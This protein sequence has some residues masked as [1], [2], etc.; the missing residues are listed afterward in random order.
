MKVLHVI[1]SISPRRGG[2]SKAVI[3]MVKALRSE[4]IDA[5]IV[6]TTDSGEYRDESLVPGEWIDYKNVPVWIH[7]CINSTSRILREYLFSP[8]MTKWLMQ[9]IKEFELVHIHAIFSYPSTIA[10]IIAR[11]KGVPYIVRTI[12]QLD[13]WSLQQ[14]PRRKKTMLLLAE[15][16]NLNC[17]SAI[18]VTSL[19]E[20]NQVCKLGLNV[21]I[22]N[23]RLGI[24]NE[25]YT[26]QKHSDS[27]VASSYKK[28]RF[29]FLSRIHPKKQ[30]DMV[31]RAFELIEK[32]TK[33]DAWELFIV[34]TGETNYIKELKKLSGELSISDKVHW[35]GYLEGK[36]KFDLLKSMDWFV[37]PSLSENFGIS[38]IEALSVGVPVIISK[39]VGVSTVVNSNKAGMICQDNPDGL[40]E[41][42]IRAMSSSSEEFSKA[43]LALTTNYFSWSCIAKELASFYSTLI[44]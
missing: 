41:V 20:Y 34:G 10:M 23:L 38:V 44:K 27:H 4:N 28:T 18:H 6:T 8:T 43:A 26:E 3:D 7:P 9:N 37:L 19:N 36:E 33:R 1:P 5:R 31:L 12:G 16:K 35:K 2:P 24:I 32:T 29:I 17:A 40:A 30:L 15:R 13:E 14:S 11:K 42:M 39:A 25:N 21:K 22:L